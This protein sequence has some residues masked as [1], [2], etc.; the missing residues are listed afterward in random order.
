MINV[1]DRELLRS[2][3]VHGNGWQPTGFF[4]DAF[5]GVLEFLH[6]G[7]QFCVTRV[8]FVRHRFYDSG[9]EDHDF[10][11]LIFLGERLAR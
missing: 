3:F 10:L 5:L 2:F 7:V 4:R 6:H 1:L 9:V 8:I 11:I